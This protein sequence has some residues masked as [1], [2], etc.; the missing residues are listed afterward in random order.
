MGLS[1]TQIKWKRLPDIN[2]S[3]SIQFLIMTSPHFF[4]GGWSHDAA[5]PLDATW[6]HHVQTVHH[7]KRRV[8]P[9]RGAL[10]DLYLRQAALVP[11]LQQRGKSP[12]ICNRCFFLHSWSRWSA[13]ASHCCHRAEAGWHPEPVASSFQCHTETGKK[14]EKQKKYKYA[15]ANSQF[16]VPKS[17]CMLVFKLWDEAKEP[18]ENLPDTGRTWKLHLESFQDQIQ[19]HNLLSVRHRCQS[20]VIWFH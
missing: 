5:N 16:R 6:E 17:P 19:T 18:R 2:R 14:T 7:R 11:A 4:Q 3:T 13:A 9:R 10:G 20:P 15:D 12:T 8:E 1:P